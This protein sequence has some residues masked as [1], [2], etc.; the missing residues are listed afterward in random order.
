M[1]QLDSNFKKF[2]CANALH[3]QQRG[4]GVFVSAQESDDVSTTRA[5]LENSSQV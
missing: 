1:V 4:R 3:E 2:A 5:E